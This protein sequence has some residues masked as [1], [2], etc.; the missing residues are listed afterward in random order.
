M[1]GSRFDALTRTLITPRRGAV[2]TLFGGALGALLAARSQEA[3]ACKNFGKQCAHDNDCCAGMKC[4]NDKCRCDN[5]FT[6]CNAKCY[7]LNTDETHC[8]ACATICAAG[9]SCCDGT[10]SDTSTD[11][12][13]CGVCGAACAAT[14]IC[15]EGVCTAC[16]VG[17]QVC[18]GVCCP[19]FRTCCDGTCVDD[20]QSNSDHCGACGNQC[21]RICPKDLDDP[22]ACHGPRCCSNGECLRGLQFD[23]DN[24][25]ACGLACAADEACCDGECVD[26]ASNS[27]HCG[28]CG[29]ACHQGRVCCDGACRDLSS[30]VEHCSACGNDCS[31]GAGVPNVSCCAGVCC[32]GRFANKRLRCCDDH[33]VDVLSDPLNCGECGFVCASLVCCVAPEG[34]PRCCPPLFTCGPVGECVF[35]G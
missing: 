11:R 14:E 13:N 34:E 21:P 5:G 9:E 27:D 3:L 15:L 35:S 23:R 20:L 24:C 30:D 31:T 29:D 1:D 2:R 6:K 10:C 33:C 26:L 17:N 25:G 16:P 22:A 28:A 18:G 7:D 8:G 12:D 32:G 19:S 4:R